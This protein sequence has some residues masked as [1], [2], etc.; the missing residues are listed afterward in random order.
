MNKTTFLTALVLLLIAVNSVTVYFLVKKGSSR[1]HKPNPA[2]FYKK[3]GLDAEQEKQF[4]ELRKAHFQKR[5][6]LRTEDM[7]LRK[8]MADMITNGVTDSLA[9]DSIT[10]LL[11]ANRK[12]FETN[13]Y[14]HFQQMHSLL[15]PEQQQK[16]GEVLEAILKRQGPPQGKK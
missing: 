9:I 6:A 13:F 16:M 12:Q 14:H 10:D 4:E 3:L 11:A 2:M 8:S 1:E 5:D 15:R 7:R